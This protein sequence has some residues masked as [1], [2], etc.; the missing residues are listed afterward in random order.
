MIIIIGA[1]ISGLYL[2]YLLQKQ[3]KDFIILEQEKRYG[4]RVYVEWFEKERVVLGAGIGRFE[5]DKILYDLCTSL[6]VPVHKYTSQISR[7]F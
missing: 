7:V 4:G 5:K 1:G 6:H 2:G 3:G